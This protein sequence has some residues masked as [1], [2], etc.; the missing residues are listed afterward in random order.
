MPKPFR[1]IALA[2]MA[3]VLAA[4]PAAAT[5]NPDPQPLPRDGDT[6]Q[7]AGWYRIKNDN[8]GLCLDVEGARTGNGAQVIQYQ[9]NGNYNQLW[10]ISGDGSIKPRHVSSLTRCLAIGKSSQ[11]NGADAIL[12]DCLGS[13]GQKWGFYQLGGNVNKI[14]NMNSQRKCLAIGRSVVAKADAILWDCIATSPGQK[15]QFYKISN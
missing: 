15:W 7:A 3:T 8:S 9:C 5:A 13:P 14:V 1:M 6:V 2:A 12:W 10:Y 11:A 4:T